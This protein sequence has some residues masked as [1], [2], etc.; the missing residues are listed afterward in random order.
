MV[1]RIPYEIAQDRGLQPQ[2]GFARK[3]THAIERAYHATITFLRQA[4]EDHSRREEY[5]AS[6]LR[7][8]NPPSSV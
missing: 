8:H 4:Q 2:Q 3:V 6:I 7:D 1:E 5:V